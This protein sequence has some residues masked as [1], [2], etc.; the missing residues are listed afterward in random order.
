MYGHLGEFDLAFDDRDEYRIVMEAFR[1]LGYV[2]LAKNPFRL[3]MTISTTK[4]S[5]GSS[6]QSD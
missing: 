2:V 6:S 4:D 3:E 5:D 1:A